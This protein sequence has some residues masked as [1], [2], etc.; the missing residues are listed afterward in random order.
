[1]SH[2]EK[3]LDDLLKSLHT[4]MALPHWYQSRS[5]RRQKVNFDL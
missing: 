1:M 3:F 4:V 2:S 5:R